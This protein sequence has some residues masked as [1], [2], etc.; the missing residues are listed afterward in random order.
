MTRIICV[1]SFLFIGC[2]VL[3]SQSFYFGPKGGLTLGLQNW[4]GF[5]RDPLIAY[6][7]AITFET[8]KEDNPNSFVIQ[9]GYHKR[10]SAENALFILGGGNAFR[11]RQN[12]QFNNAVLTFAGKRLLGYTEGPQPYYT[13]G[14]RIEYT[15]S[16]NL[17]QYE[18]YAGYF[19][20][21]AFVNKFNYGASIGFGFEKKISELVGAYVE[22][23]ISP[24]LSKQYEQI[25]Q[26]TIISPLTG[27]SITLRDQAIRNITFELSVGFKF[28]R[29]VVYLSDY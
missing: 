12:F 25:G 20:I 5:E 7:G 1:L 4:N 3:P 22:A 23:V 17:Q 9:L 16:T 28:L 29:K 13:F 19:P 26:F 14:A 8:Y 18:Q 6:H 2:S 10:G 15:V 24:D 21:D 27:Q 11:Q